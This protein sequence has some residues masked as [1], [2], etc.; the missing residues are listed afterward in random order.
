MNCETAKELLF[1]YCAGELSEQEAAD[2]SSMN[3]RIGRH[4]LVH[5]P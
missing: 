1:D 2:V 4:L 3:V 5:E